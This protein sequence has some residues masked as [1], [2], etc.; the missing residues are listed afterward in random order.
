M[1]RLKCRMFLDVAGRKRPVISG[2]TEKENPHQ[3]AEAIIACNVLNRMMG[4]GRPE[5]FAIAD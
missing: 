1:R 5:S 3:E 2:R 4:L